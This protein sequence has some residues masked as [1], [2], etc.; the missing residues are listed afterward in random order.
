MS[1]RAILAAVVLV[2]GVGA[3]IFPGLY[4]PR[5]E[6]APEYATVEWTRVERKTVGGTVQV[7]AQAR[8]LNV[9]RTMSGLRPGQQITV[10]YKAAVPDRDRR[11]AGCS[12]PPMPVVVSGTKTPVFL[13]RRQGESVYLP[14]A[15][16]VSFRE[17]P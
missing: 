13:Y 2:P 16:H 10:R 12:T 17:L 6:R 7:V 3:S 14:A 1:F 9:V 5:Q 8:L 15:G 4:K 11:P